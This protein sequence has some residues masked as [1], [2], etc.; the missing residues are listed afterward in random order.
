MSQSK[1]ETSMASSM[2]FPDDVLG[3]IRA[4][5]RPRMQFIHEYN[6]IVRVLGIEWYPVKK[7]L[8]TPDA[9][10]VLEQ[11]A[12][13]ADGV[14]MAR[15]AEADVPVL[16][17]ECT[18]VEHMVWLLASRNYSMYL[19]VVKARLRTLEYMVNKK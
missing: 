1:I 3:L 8:E 18:C 16:A 15:Q 11:F 5:A 10:K 2:E 6:E 17:Q 12:Y 14:V 7:K 13:Y 4:Y 9:E 19:D